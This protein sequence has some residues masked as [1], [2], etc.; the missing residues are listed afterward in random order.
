MPFMSERFG[1]TAYPLIIPTIKLAPVVSTAADVGAAPPCA[2]TLA[3]SAKA[4]GYPNVIATVAA[5]RAMNELMIPAAQAAIDAL[6]S[7]SPQVWR[8]AVS[9]V[10]LLVK[11]AVTTMLALLGSLTAL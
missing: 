1:V 3:T 4:I 2:R 9:P 6:L 10:D 8:V 7:V 11:T 5:S